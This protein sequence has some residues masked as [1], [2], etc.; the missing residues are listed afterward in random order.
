MEFLEIAKTLS[1]ALALLVIGMAYAITKLW[2]KLN[3]KDKQIMEMFHKLEVL[4]S[5]NTAQIGKLDE[6]FRFFEHKIVEK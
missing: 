1:P 3:E 2:G 5:L 4:I 6:V